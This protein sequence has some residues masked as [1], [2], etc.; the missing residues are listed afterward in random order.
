MK[1]IYWAIAAIA[2]LLLVLATWHSITSADRATQQRLD[3]FR[4]DAEQFR[5]GDQD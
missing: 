2:S 1:P 3:E 5:Q 4:Q